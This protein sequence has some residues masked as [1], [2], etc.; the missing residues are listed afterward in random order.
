MFEPLAFPFTLNNG[1]GYQ[2]LRG[3]R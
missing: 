1:P 2:D 3:Q